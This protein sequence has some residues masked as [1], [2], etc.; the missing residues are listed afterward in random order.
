[1]A[2]NQLI[3]TLVKETIKN[4]HAEQSANLIKCLELGYPDLLVSAGEIDFLFGDG[5]AKELTIR[6]DSE[7][8]A[9]WHG[10]T[11]AKQIFDTHSLWKKLGIDP[12]TIDMKKIRGCEQ[13][14]DLNYPMPSDYKCR[15]DLAI[16]TGTLEHCFNVGQAFINLFESLKAG[17]VAIHAFPV[18]RYNHGFWSAN[19]TLYH[20]LC[21]E[22]DLSI[23]WLRGVTFDNILFELPAHQRFKEIPENTAIVACIR[24]DTVSEFVFPVQRKYRDNS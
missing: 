18:N 2:I 12:T 6:D 15:F 23:L 3:L 17:G 10:Y 16:D 20:D 21:T 22:N 24:R 13:L 5:T 1:M 4:H 7:Q 9:Q 19:P 11:G 8:I 14:V